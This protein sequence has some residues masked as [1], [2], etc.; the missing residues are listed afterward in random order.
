MKVVMLSAH[1]LPK[2]PDL[3]PGDVHEFDDAEAERL[4]SVKG[5][6]AL[7]ADELEAEAAKA[8]PPAKAAAKGVD[9]PPATK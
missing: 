3:M 9:A 6:R 1:L 7:T 2:G 8:A 4:I 5:A